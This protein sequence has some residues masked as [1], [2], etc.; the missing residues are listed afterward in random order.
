MCGP[1]LTVYSDLGDSFL[2]LGEEEMDVGTFTI[3]ARGGAKRL[4]AWTRDNG[5]R[6]V[7][8]C[9]TGTITRTGGTTQIETTRPKDLWLS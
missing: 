3:V 2:D 6:P 8:A 7:A 4:A 5:G 9:L 1:V